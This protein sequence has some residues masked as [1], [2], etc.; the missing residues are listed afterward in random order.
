[1]GLI[2]NGRPERRDGEKILGIF[3]NTLPFR[4]SLAGGSWADLAR[5]AFESER[6]M[7][8]YRRFP[9]VE[10]QRMTGGQFLSDA[11]FNYTNFHV[12]RRLDRQG[13]VD[14]WGGY[15]FEQTYFALTAQFNL[16]EVSASVAAALD[17]RSAD[18]TRGQVE[19]IAAVYG[20]VLA[21]MAADPLARH[22]TFSILTPDE[23]RRVLVEWNDTRR[24]APLDRCV[25]EL[26]EAQAARTPGA[27]AVVDG[28]TRLTYSELNDRANR[29]A[30]RLM[31]LGIGPEA[32]VAVC[33]RRSHELIAALLGV[34]KAGGAYVPLDPAY[35]KERLA[36]MLD[37]A[38]APVLITESRL[39]EAFPPHAARVLC[40]DGDG[41]S[42]DREPEDNPRTGVLPEN[43]AY[44]IYNSDSTGR[45]KGAAI[46][47][48]STV[49]LL[50]WAR[51]AFGEEVLSG[52]LA[53]SSVCFDSS[54]L[55]IFAPLSWGG[56]IILAENALHLPSLAG[57]D[58][59]RLVNTVPSAIAELVRAGAVP[60]SVRTVS[61][62]GEAL[63]TPLV[64]EIYKQET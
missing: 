64:Q 30:H 52:V 2:A 50:H 22:D 26:F 28:A 39:L 21:A 44:V 53:S 37:D 61:L 56:T 42:L 58:Q 17:Y 46:E 4:M 13:G 15:G 51:E 8:P 10:L 19:E 62:A 59:V 35:P 54:V 57:R 38:R 1:T 34:L 32:P 60:A 41:E 48:R 3:L 16:D 24:A 29:V 36:F 20:R 43:L 9:M 14:L 23:R 12:V 6:E 11:A 31:R 25:H 40:L 47:H 7:L 33:H 27:V 63:R 55:E 5:R 18:L 45:P 49:S